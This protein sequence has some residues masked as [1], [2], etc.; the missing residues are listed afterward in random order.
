[1]RQDEARLDRQCKQAACDGWEG[2]QPGA[3]KPFLIERPRRVGGQAFDVLRTNILWV[4]GECVCVCV[5][6]AAPSSNPGGGSWR[7]EAVAVH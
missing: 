6:V 1:M 3:G 5:C 2:Q 7:G 4:G